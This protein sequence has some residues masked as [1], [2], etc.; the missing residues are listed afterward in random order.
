MKSNKEIVTSF[1]QSVWNLRQLER[2]DDFVSDNYRDFSFLPAIPPTRDGLRMWIENTTVAFDHHTTIESMIEEYDQVAVR[3]SFEV[4]HIGTWRGI[5][6][7]GRTTS[8]KGFRFFKLEGG[9]ISQHWALLDGEA[10]QTALTDQYH[11]CE[12]KL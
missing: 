9:K 3:I 11:G 10:L 2:I 6:P 12:I 8:V 5:A 7:T 4:R 1:I